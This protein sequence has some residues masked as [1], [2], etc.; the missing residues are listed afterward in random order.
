MNEEQ[1]HS[2]VSLSRRGGNIK[3][4]CQDRPEPDSQLAT[5]LHHIA[6]VGVVIAIVVHA[7][8][9]TC[10]CTYNIWA[11]TIVSKNFQMRYIHGAVI[12]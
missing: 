8:E 5:S 10:N 6:V 11:G 9:G 4:R 2:R 7:S 3:E 1:R 12:V